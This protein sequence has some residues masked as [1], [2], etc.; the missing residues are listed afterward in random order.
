MSL[1][2]SNSKPLIIAKTG[3]IGNTVQ[4]YGGNMDAEI[5]LKDFCFL[6]EYVLTNSDIEPNVEDPRIDLMTRIKNAKI[7]DGFNLGKKRIEI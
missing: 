4:L 1:E 3:I 6:V 5:P 7:V 2:L